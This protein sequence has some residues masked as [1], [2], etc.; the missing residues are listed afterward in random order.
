MKNLIRAEIRYFI[1]SKSFLILFILFSL[2]SSATIYMSYQYSKS[3]VFTY[4][5]TYQYIV[6]TGADIEKEKD[7][8]Y[9]VHDNGMIE[10]PLSYDIE[11]AENALFYIA[12]KNC[13]TSFG[14]SCTLFLPIIAFLIAIILV[15]YDEKNKTK[16]LK[17]ANYGKLKFNFSKQL[18]G[19][20]IILLLLILELIIIKVAS[21]IAYSLLQNDNDISPFNIRNSNMKDSIFQLL[22]T[23]CSAIVYFELGYC[24]SNIFHCYTFAAILVSIFSF[25]LPPI[26]KYDVINIK[27]TI[28]RNFFD[29]KG[30]VDIG[31]GFPLSLSIAFIEGSAILLCCILLN[32]LVDKNRSAFS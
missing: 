4:N 31:V 29:F 19:I 26:F 14:E 20:L 3:S 13:I 11:Q 2:C 18:S 27:N 22:Y 12:P 25:F 7:M 15:S 10:N 9:V 28:E 32:C 6:D 30:V 17:V 1:Y 23:I 8:Q 21:H 24:I 16:K 5:D